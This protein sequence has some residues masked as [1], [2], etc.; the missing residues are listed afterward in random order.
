MLLSTQDAKVV[1]LRT[2]F[3]AALA[4]SLGAQMS[5]LVNSGLK[6]SVRINLGF[7]EVLAKLKVTQPSLTNQSGVPDYN[8]GI[9]KILKYLLL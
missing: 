8:T 7:K 6:I 2:L 5:L 3:F 1:K 9:E 4:C